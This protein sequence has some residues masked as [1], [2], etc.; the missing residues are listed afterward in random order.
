MQCE[1]PDSQSPCTTNALFGGTGSVAGV[2]QN[3]LGSP[4]YCT[5]PG[6]KEDSV[7]R[8]DTSSEEPAVREAD[9]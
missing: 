3:S 1:G 5:H 6:V 2:C 4:D 7:P 8:R 9:P